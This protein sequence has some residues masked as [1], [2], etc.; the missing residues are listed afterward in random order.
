MVRQIDGPVLLV[1]HSYGGAVIPEA[2]GLPNATGLVYVAAFA[3][4]AGESPGGISREQPP[5]ALENI[6]PDSDGCLWIRPEKFRESFAQDL[7]TEEGL[8]TA[9]TRKAPLASAFGDPVTAPAWRVKPRWYQ[10]SAQDRMVHPDD[11]RRMA[12]RMD[13]RKTVELDASHASLA[14]QP[15]AVADLIE[16]AASG[17]GA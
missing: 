17:S 4:D 13:P 5:A 3:P 8:V 15:R 12:A 6:A 7:S 10:V 11:E 2:G 9:V 14:S 1:G 16:A